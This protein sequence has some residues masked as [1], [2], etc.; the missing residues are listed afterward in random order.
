MVHVILDIGTQIAK[1]EVHVLRKEG[2]LVGGKDNFT[3]FWT[4]VGDAGEGDAAVGDGE[5]VV[6]HGLVGPLR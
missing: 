1:V 6:D 4:D 2:I 5:E 3:Q